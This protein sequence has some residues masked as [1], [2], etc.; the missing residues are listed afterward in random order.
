MRYGIGRNGHC[1]E[2]SLFSKKTIRR[3]LHCAP[4]PADIRKISRLLEFGL[5]SKEATFDARSTQIPTQTT[6]ACDNAGR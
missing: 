2:I 5:L 1:T 6:R 3:N 4:D